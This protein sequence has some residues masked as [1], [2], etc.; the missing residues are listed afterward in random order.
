MAT[1]PQPIVYGIS[2]LNG[3]PVRPNSRDVLA[4]SMKT[5]QPVEVDSG[6][7]YINLYHVF[8]RMQQRDKKLR[9]YV[10]VRKQIGDSKWRLFVTDDRKDIPEVELNPGYD[11]KRG[12]YKRYAEELAEGNALSFTDKA[13]AIKARR[14]WQLYVPR[15]KRRQLRSQI[16]HVS[17]SGKYLVSVVERDVT[18]D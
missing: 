8:E 3:I 4:K 15:E 17:K 7:D 11:P 14:A 2:E 10:L 16:R 9:G 12:R 5:G 18:S 13:E 1:N 6:N